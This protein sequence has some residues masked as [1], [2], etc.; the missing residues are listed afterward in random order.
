LGEQEKGPTNE[1]RGGKYRLATE[2]QKWQSANLPISEKVLH[3]PSPG[4]KRR[5]IFSSKKNPTPAEKKRWQ[6]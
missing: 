2:D 6:S 5:Q 1:E 4:G 3:R